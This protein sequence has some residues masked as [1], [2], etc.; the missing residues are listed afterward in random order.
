MFADILIVAGAIALSGFL[1]WFFFGKRAAAEATV[2]GGVQEVTVV[3]QGGYSPN[4]IRA[5]KGVPL[6]INFDRR[7][8]T[9]CTSRVIF[10]DLKVSKSLPASP[11][12]PWSWSPR[13]RESSTSVA[14]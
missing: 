6:R 1:G 10:P 2:A 11:P 12:P 14:R 13:K 9:D 5:R 4:V 7:E 3:V 8:G